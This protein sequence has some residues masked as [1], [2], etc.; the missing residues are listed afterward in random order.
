[1]HEILQAHCATTL[2]GNRRH[3]KINR[4]NARQSVNEAAAEMFA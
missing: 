2:S 3:R 1:M 4:L